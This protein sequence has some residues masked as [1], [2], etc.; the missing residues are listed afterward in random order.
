MQ[1]FQDKLLAFGMAANNQKYLKVI[2]N[3][4]QKLMPLTMVGAIAVL[5]CNVLVHEQTGLGAFFKPIMAL[6]FL[7]P[8]FDA[9][10]FATI[11][12]I[13][14]WITVLIGYELGTENKSDGVA[15]ALISAAALVSVSQTSQII[16]ETTIQG[17]FSGSLGSNGLFTGMIVAI[18]ASELFAKLEKIDALKIKLPPQVPAGVAKPFEI[19]IPSFIVFTVVSIMGLLIQNST[20]LFVNDLIFN[21]VQKPLVNIGGS[22]PGMIIFTLVSCLFWS[23]GLHGDNMIG[24]VLNPI[25]T[26][27]TTANLEAVSAGLKPTNIINGTWQRI[28]FA[29]GGTGMVLG[30]TLAFLIFGKREE[31]KALCKMALPANIFNIGEVNMFGLP[32]VLNPTLI[33]P[34][35]LAPIVTMIFGYFATSLGLCPIMYN[36]VP[37]TMPLFF[38]GWI[39]SGNLMGGVMQLIA[40]AISVCIY[41]P[42][43]KIY[44][45]Q[46]AKQAGEIE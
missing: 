12:C 2:K 29:T 27:L 46:Q 4:F 38:Y 7:N 1:V 34:F 15:S 5:W 13:A 42:F 17:I 31:N 44:E 14:L 37:W 16:G 30:L 28:F 41:A 24:G 45:K 23:V 9:I 26:A 11:N 20:G 18:I 3:A 43:I 35:I 6:K 21:L 8:A 32:V 40:V 36:N 25:L 10:N 19:M 39:A 22:L 33:I